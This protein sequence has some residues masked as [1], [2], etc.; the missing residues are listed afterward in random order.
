MGDTTIASKEEVWKQVYKKVATVFVVFKV[1]SS[2]VLVSN[3][4]CLPLTG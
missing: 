2:L 1:P 3:Q 4:T